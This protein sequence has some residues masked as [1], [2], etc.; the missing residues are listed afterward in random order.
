M[1]SDVDAG[2]SVPRDVPLIDL[3]CHLTTSRGSMKDMF[4]LG[5]DLC[6]LK[7]ELYFCV[8]SDTVAVLFI[9]LRP[10]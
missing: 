5:R 10:G 8:P 7:A 1:D 4:S 9:V 2:N 3:Q 6:S